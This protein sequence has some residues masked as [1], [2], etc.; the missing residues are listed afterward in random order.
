MITQ[1]SVTPPAAPS[2][3]WA[4]AR[5]VPQILQLRR[6][7]DF[8]EAEKCQPL[9]ADLGEQAITSEADEV[10][11]ASQH[12][13]QSKLREAEEALERLRAGTYGICEDCGAAIS[14]DRLRALPTARRCIKCESH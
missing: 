2:A 12:S 9:E 11:S 4:W 10:S 8:I 7:L 6:R 13:V 1:A 3:E 14:G 5:L